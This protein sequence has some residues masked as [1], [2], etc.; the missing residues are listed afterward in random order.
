MPRIRRQTRLFQMEDREEIAMESVRMARRSVLFLSDLQKDILEQQI[1]MPTPKVS[2]FQIYSYAAGWDWVILGIGAICAVAGGA[3]LP[4]FTVFFG[5]ITSTFRDV[6]SYAITY[7]EFYHT[8]STNVYYFI[9]LGIGEFLTLGFATFAFVHT[10]NSVTQKIRV[11]YLQAILQQNIA[12]FDSLGAG[13]IT[14]RITGDMHLIQDGI[15]EKLSLVLTGVSSFVTAFVIAFI[16]YW[17]LALVS[18]STLFVLLLIMGIGSTIS[19][20]YSKKSIE[21]YGKGGSIADNVLDSI[22]TVAAFGAQEALAEKYDSHLQDAERFGRVVQMT[23]ALVIGGILGVMYLNYGL[24]LWMGSRFLIEDPAHIAPGDILTIMMSIILGS[25]SLGNV[26]P[27][28]QAFSDAVA[29]ATKILGTI[30]RESPLN[31][32]S[33]EGN[34]PSSVQGW[35][36]FSNIKHAYPSRP[37]VIVMEDFNLRIPAGK[38]T[39]FVGPS[40]S[41][42]STIIGLLERFYNPVGGNV[43]IDGHDIQSLNLQWLR[44]QISLVSQEPQLFSATIFENIK[45]GLIGSDFENET[46]EEIRERVIK[47]AQIADAD[48]FINA[49]PEGY[50]TNIGSL[51]L[52]GGQKQRIAIARAIVKEPKILLLD[53]AT[54]ALD[55]KSEGLVQAALDRAAEGRTTIVIAHRLS[56]IKSAHNIVVMVGGKIAEQGTHKQLLDRNGTYAGL[57]QAQSISDAYGNQDEEHDKETLAT[58]WFDEDDDFDRYWADDPYFTPLTL[59]P[60]AS[61]VTVP[62]LA[63]PAKATQFSIWSLIKFIASFNHPE[64]YIMGLALVISLFAGCVQPAQSVLLAKAVNAMSMPYT[65]PGELR[66]ETNFWSSMFLMTGLVTFVLFG[67]QGVMFAVSSEKLIRRARSQT[68]RVLLGQ[69]I[70]FF[71]EEENSTGALTSALATDIKNLAGISGATLAT[72][73]I[74][75]MNLFGSLAVAMALGWKLA[76]VCSSAVPVLLLSGFLRTWILSRFQVRGRK[77]HQKSASEVSEA[78]TAIRTVVSLTMERVILDSYR[79][80]LEQQV[81]TDIPSILRSSYLYASSEALQFFCMALGFW[82]GGMLLGH[83]EY[84]IFKFYVC[85]SEVIFGAQAAGTV[86]SYAP[87]MSK[88][89][90]AAAEL[91]ALFSRKPKIQGCVGGEVVRSLQGSIEFRNVYFRYPTRIQYPVLQGLNLTVQPGQFIAFVGASG[92]GKSTTIA[93]LERFYNPIAGEILVDGKDISTLD[94]QSYRKKLAYVGQEP[95]LFQGT[96]RENILLG[97]DP[98]EVSDGALITACRDANIY[99]FIISLPQG[100]NTTVGS[101]GGMLSGGQK[102]RIAIARA[103]LRNPRILLLDEA[104]SALDSESEKVV[105]AALDTAARGRTTLAVAHRLSTIQRA[106]MIYVLANGQVAESGT[107]SELLRKRGRYFDLVNLQNLA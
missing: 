83:H 24:G 46:A 11:R 6:A 13:E 37:E 68:F 52:S 32:L 100:F 62:K 80:Q 93:L 94:L 43:L 23:F 79:T 4:L 70:A 1:R 20:I 56:T 107:H 14:T 38:T 5:N 96:I 67:T 49:L 57:V 73:L 53:E 66:H 103:L 85:F 104:T 42:K 51:A 39:A 29:A 58:L 88:A 61:N 9:Y 28:M 75:T 26:A 33:T 60:R 90:H 47:A 25:Y 105:Q 102:Q 82:Y 48:E 106:D 18:T 69:D 36:E 15:S 72:L 8:L 50:E 22:R 41:G 92:C 34:R 19:V 7:D 99:E 27:N 2:Y 71:D 101:K 64:R 89:R 35:I 12:F 65:E 40:G 78:V 31:P 97:M 91:K 44:Q 16:K 84:T 17:K 59:C 30:D 21:C 81:K 86:F 45:Y 87:G 3:A 74:V 55:T 98:H 77:M 10:G 95:A 63:A 76:L 54:S